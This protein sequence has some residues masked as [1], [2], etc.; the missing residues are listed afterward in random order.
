MEATSL[1]ISKVFSGGG[2]IHYILP[3][4]QR[5]YTWEK[6]HWDTIL[7]DAFAIYDE[8]PI[9]TEDQPA[10][11]IE[12]FLGSLVVIKDGM[13]NGTLPA[14]KL[15]DGQQRLTTISLMICALARIA[16]STHPT[17]AK[18]AFKLLIN[19]DA[20][21]DLHYK[22]LPTTK[23]GD[24]HAYTKIIAGEAIPDVDSG[25]SKAYLYLHRELDKKINEKGYDPEKLFIVFTNSFQVVF[26]DLNHNE[27]PYKI[28]ESL[29][30]KGKPLSQADLVRNYIAMK[31]PAAG[32]EHIFAHYWS[33]IETMLQEKRLVGRSGFGELT[34]FLRHYLS[35]KSGVL[36]SVAHVYARF[37]DRIERDFASA[38][39]FEAEIERLLYFA[40]IYN[41]LLRPEHEPRAEIREAMQRLAPLELS[42]AYPFLL[43]VADAYIKGTI[44][45]E[46]YKNCWTILENYL[47]RRYITGEPSNFLNNFF[48]TL[49]SQIDPANFT[50]SLRVILAERNYLGDARV[51]QAIFD[52]TFYD[53][54]AFTRDRTT[55]ILESIN[56]H[57]SSGSGGYTVLNDNPTI[58]H[59]MP[60]TLSLEWQTELGAEWEQT[61]RDLLHTLGNLTLVTQE[62]NSGLSNSPFADKQQKFATH[63]LRLNSEYFSSPRPIWNE[64]SIRERADFLAN[65][66]LSIWPALAAPRTTS[67]NASSKPVLLTIRG[68][69]YPVS[70]WSDVL[71]QTAEYI[72]T[73]APDFAAIAQRLPL[74]LSRQQF[75]ARSHQLSNGWWLYINLSSRDIKRICGE[76]LAAAGIPSTDWSVAERDHNRPDDQLSTIHPI[77]S[78]EQLPFGPL[79]DD[80][81]LMS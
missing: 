56:R 63:A 47:V 2:E 4:F 11:D 6:Q 33:E 37:R 80:E 17:L 35:M 72:A 46:D 73:T 29:N 23:Y 76:L 42:T 48:P 10:P 12:H 68:N 50:A 79:F 62:W 20:T 25:I 38:S 51:K 34:A 43:L 67:S 36:I 69:E 22:I 55:F 18:R 3:H 44:S 66:I 1:R 78:S 31:L 8:M 16:A 81:N 61:H 28:F 30:A 77:P 74:Y 70:Y 59:I 13:R 27:S 9:P 14:F 26:I 39:A 57:L 54:S 75:Q 52:R 40:R 71:R 64:T 45:A 21:G 15:V 60:Q 24:R 53:K 5:E 49:W 65:Q 41:T 58:E 7:Q 19:E 32:Q